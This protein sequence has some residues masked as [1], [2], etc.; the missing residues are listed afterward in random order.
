MLPNVGTPFDVASAQNDPFSVAVDWLNV[1]WTDDANGSGNGAVMMAP[2]RGGPP[3]TLSSGGVPVGIAVDATN[4]YWTDETCCVMKK[5][6]AGGQA[7]TLAS[8]QN[9]EVPWRWTPSR[10]PAETPRTSTG[11]TLRAGW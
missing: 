11:Q 5:P 6:L 2:V 10:S 1:Y 9:L 7:V 3:M 8:G 4:V